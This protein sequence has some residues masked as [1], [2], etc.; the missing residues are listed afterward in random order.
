[1]PTK[2]IAIANGYIGVNQG[3]VDKAM[4]RFKI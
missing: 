3:E 1:M 4:T 2:N